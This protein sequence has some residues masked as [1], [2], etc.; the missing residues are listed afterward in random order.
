MAWVLRDTMNT[1]AQGSDNRP[2]IVA[3]AIIPILLLSMVVTGFLAGHYPLPD[4][5]AITL[6]LLGAV[7]VVFFDLFLLVYLIG[8][9]L[10]ERQLA[11]AVKGGLLILG[12]GLLIAPVVGVLPWSLRWLVKSNPWIPFLL[13]ALLPVW[14]IMDLIRLRKSPRGTRYF[15][16]YCL[17]FLAFLITTDYGSVPPLVR[18]AVDLLMIVGLIWRVLL[19]RKQRRE[20]GSTAGPA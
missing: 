6:G 14:M 8:G 2:L 11:A 5:N 19:I 20:G 4:D 13:A 12:L 18:G 10:R 3:L 9:K 17:T 7:F 15:N 16:L 1:R